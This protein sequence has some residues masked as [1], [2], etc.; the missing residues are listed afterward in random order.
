[1][2]GGV[3]GGTLGGTGTGTLAFG[4]GMNRPVLISGP[5]GTQMPQYTREAREASI[6]GIMLVKC[7][8]TTEGSVTSCQ[9]IKPVPHMDQAVLQWLAAAKYSPVTFQGHPQAVSYVFNFRFKLQ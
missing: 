4:E 9:I 6:E 1:M 8:I 7:T 5:G 2:V 3:V